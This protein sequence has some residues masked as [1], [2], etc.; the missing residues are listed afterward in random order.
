MILIT[1]GDQL[2]PAKG[3]PVTKPSLR[4]VLE[5]FLRE[6]SAYDMFRVEEDQKMDVGRDLALMEPCFTFLPL[7]TPD[8]GEVPPDTFQTLEEGV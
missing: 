4:A 5:L 8:R 3:D 6:V 1:S 7:H 2:V